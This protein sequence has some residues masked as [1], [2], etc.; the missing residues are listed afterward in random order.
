MNWPRPYA[1]IMCGAVFWSVIAAPGFA[2]GSA[3][4]ALVFTDQAQVHS[5]TR[6]IDVREEQAC[7]KASLAGARCLPA[8]ELFDGNGQPA[9]F[10]VLRWLLGTIGLTGHEQVLVVAD[11][12][13]DAAAVGALLFL[14][15]ERHVAVLDRPVAVPDGAPAGNA[16]SITREAVFTA[17]LRDHLLAT[18]QE[19][20]AGT[21]IDS[22]RPVDRL[23]AFARRYAD[24]AQPARLRLFP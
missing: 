23:R 8:A 21:V 16:R 11:N 9:T 20:A 3:P 22:G 10:Y 14:A 19:E 13:A 17:P 12:A 1:R 6:V 24:G 15:G 18:G 7:A 2:A 5:D 4:T